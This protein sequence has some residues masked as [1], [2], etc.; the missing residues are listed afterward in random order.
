VSAAHG[1][2]APATPAGSAPLTPDVPPAP[3][4]A[5]AARRHAQVIRVRP[6]HYE[7]YRALHAQVWPEVLARIHAC[8]IRNYSIHHRDGYL[9]AYYEYVGEDHDADMRRMA[10]D[11]ATQRWW[12]LTAPCQEKVASAGADEWWAPMDEL[13]FTP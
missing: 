10:A 7:E 2:D 4:G 6:E 1:T 12:A 13:F 5:R 8:N 9:F 11:A 3:S